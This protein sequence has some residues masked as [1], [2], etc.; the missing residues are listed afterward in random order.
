MTGK[1]MIDFRRNI[2]FYWGYLFSFE[3]YHEL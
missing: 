2:I 3:L 1:I